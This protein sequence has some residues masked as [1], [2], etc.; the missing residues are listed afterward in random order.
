VTFLPQPV[1]R[2]SQVNE[3]DCSGAVHHKQQPAFSLGHSP[4]PHTRTLDTAAMQPQS[5]V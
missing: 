4:C 2:A 3:L 5:A 1:Y